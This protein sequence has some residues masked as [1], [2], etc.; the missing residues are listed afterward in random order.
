MGNGG[1]SGYNY[2]W[3]E[4]KKEKTMRKCVLVER[5]F[6]PREYKKDET[7]KTISPMVIENE[8]HTTF[9]ELPAIY[10]FHAFCSDG[11]GEG[12]NTAC[13][14]IEDRTGQVS[15]VLAERIKFMEP[16]A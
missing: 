3:S 7:G 14:V 10:T 4:P 12:G 1:T 11:D 6:H 9:T 13:A 16:S 2:N 15:T 5:K 8:A